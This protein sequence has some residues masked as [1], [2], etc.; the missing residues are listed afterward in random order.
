MSA[1]NAF[2]FPCRDLENIYKD[3]PSGICVVPDK[4]NITLVEPPLPLLSFSH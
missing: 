4:D 1:T 2:A 3:P